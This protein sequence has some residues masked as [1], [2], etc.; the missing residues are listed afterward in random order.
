MILVTG[1]SGF[2]GLHTVRALLDLGHNCVVTQHQTVRCPDFIKEEIGQR[3]FI[4]QVDLANPQAVLD[5]GQRHKITGIIH[6]AG[7]GLGRLGLFENL[8][9]SLGMLFNVLEAAREWSV[10]RVS[11]ASAIG[12]YLGVEDNPFREDMALPMIAVH[13]IQTVK[14][15]SELLANFVGSQAGFEI[16]N[17]R[18]GA[19]WGPLGRPTSPFFLT[20]RLIHAAVK[21]EMLNLSAANPPAYPEDGLDMCYVKDCGRAIALLQLSPKLNHATYNIGSGYPTTN[22]ELVYAIKQIIP[23]VKFELAE[24]YHP[25]ASTGALYLDITRLKEDTGYQPAYSLEAGVADY[26]AWLRTGN[27]R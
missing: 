10:K 15:S 25:Q 24:G 9:V 5:M 22:R 12:V 8:R 19:I 4:E 18:I 7:P 2:I 26:I 14:K 27:E 16:V 20:P 21:G 1:G 3:V 23:E 13:P 17:L 6:L 11:I